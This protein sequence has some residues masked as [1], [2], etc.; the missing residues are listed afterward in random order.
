MSYDEEYDSYEDECPKDE[1]GT[2]LDLITEYNVG[3]HFCETKEDGTFSVEPL[4]IY[5]DWVGGKKY[6]AWMTAGDLFKYNLKPLKFD[7]RTAAS[8]LAGLSLNMY[9][10]FMCPAIN[11]NDNPNPEPLPENV[12]ENLGIKD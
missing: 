2:D 3:V 12:K 9:M 8:R 6:C 7:L 5:S 4:Y 11:L 10:A 1:T